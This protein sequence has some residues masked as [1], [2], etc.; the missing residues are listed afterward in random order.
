M[1]FGWMDGWI[2]GWTDRRMDDF[3]MFYQIFSSPRMKRGTIISNKQGIHQLHQEL[4]ND[5][6][7]KVLGN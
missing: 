4:Q 6:R 5:L 1:D 7:L 3:F 2:D